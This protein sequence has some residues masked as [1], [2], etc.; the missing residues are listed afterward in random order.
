[1]RNPYEKSRRVE[2][3]YNRQLRKVA[4]HVGDLAMGFPD[5][6]VD[7]LVLAS[8]EEAMR[9]YSAAIKPWAASVGKRMVEDVNRQDVESFNKAARSM[10]RGLKQ[11]LARAPVAETMRDLQR[12]QVR[13][14]TSLPTEASQRVHRLTQE[15][16]TTGKR[17]AQIAEEIARTSE[18][19]E[20]RA[21]LIARTEVARTG[22]KLT[23]TRAI[24]VGS[25]G[26][27]WRTSKDSDVRESHQQMEGRF[28][29]WANPP[30][31]SDGTTTH[32]GQ[33]YN[34]RC[35]PEPVIPDD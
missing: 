3:W 25:T 15:A 19:T 16:L 27:I 2:L 20:S 35:Y 28:C 4:K 29:E 8:L 18:V 14:I 7:P 17:A 30:T 11:E 10:S 24:S 23:E 26:Y 32:A 12:E 5:P 22:S 33:I 1:M 6:I 31:L 21:A 34:C 13:L 9:A